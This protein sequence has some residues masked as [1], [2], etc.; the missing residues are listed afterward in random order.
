M[1]A[2]SCIGMRQMERA[3]THIHDAEQYQPAQVRQWQHFSLL[4]KGDS[5]SPLLG[6]RTDD[7]SPH[8]VKVAA[9]FVRFKLHL[10][11]GCQESVKA[12]LAHMINCE[13]FSVDCLQVY[14]I[15]GMLT[16]C[17][18]QGGCSWEAEHLLCCLIQYTELPFLAKTRK[19]GVS[20]SLQHWRL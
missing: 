15:A 6:T 10:Q 3:L 4:G 8:A 20:R 13:D 16:G 2:L 1:M 12:E 14:N 5:T 9:S 18:Q 17:H 11:A 19:G 7:S